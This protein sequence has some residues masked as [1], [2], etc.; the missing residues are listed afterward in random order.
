VFDD[1]LP[2]EQWMRQ[3]P[4]IAQHTPYLDIEH[5][6]Y[7]GRFPPAPGKHLYSVIGLRTSESRNRTAGL[8]ASM[9]YICKPNN[10]G[11]RMVR[12]IYDWGDGDVWKAIDDNH[13]DY[14]A[15][16]DAMHRLGMP[17]KNLRI[18]PPTLNI[19]GSKLLGLSAKAWPQWFDKLCQRLPGVR[20]AALFG[21]SAI[22]PHRRREETW[23]QCYQRECI[24]NAPG[25]IADRSIL[26]GR[27][28]LKRHQNHTAK[29]FPDVEPCPHCSMT[30]IGSWKQL[31]HMMYLGDPLNLKV[32]FLPT[33]EPEFFRPGAGKWGGKPTW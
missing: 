3:P 19:Y 24:D 26:A 6:T 13:W 27:Y 14:N 20:T 8:F 4:P 28:M 21:R 31:A 7:P 23:E 5:M 25:W 11:V 29:P 18:A 12:P 1:R 17:R 15:A 16:Y 22:Q 32:K 9:G 30:N 2:P 10:L 33:I